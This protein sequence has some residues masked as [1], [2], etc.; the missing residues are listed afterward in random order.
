MPAQFMRNEKPKS[1]REEYRLREIQRANDSVS[2]AKKFP[3]LKSLTM[4]FEYLNAAGEPRNRNIKY[5]VN[6]TFAKSVFRLD[7][8]NSDCVC[9]D[10]D[11]SEAITQVF[12]DRQA[13]VSGEMRC[14]GW[15]DQSKINSRRCHMILRYKLSLEYQATPVEKPD[16]QP[17]LTD[18]KQ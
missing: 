5:T 6:P 12:R 4:E 11:L 8:V 7:C 14:Q 15:L 3:E 17:V 2:L 13:S 10:F 1:P 9:G 18:L 16:L